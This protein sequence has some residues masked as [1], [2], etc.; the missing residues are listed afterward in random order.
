[1]WGLIAFPIVAPDTGTDKIF[2]RVITTARLRD[3]MIDREGN[4]G[5][6]AVLA[7]MSVTAKDILA[8]EYNALVRNAN[9][10]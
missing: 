7:S 9:V 6:A 3:N 4:V 8:G 5:P 1:M 2:P 10:D